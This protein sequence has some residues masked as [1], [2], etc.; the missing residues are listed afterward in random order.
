MESDL[1]QGLLTED[2]FFDFF[3]QGR[4]TPAVSR[5]SRSAQRQ[6]QLEN[7]DADESITKHNLP[8]PE[9]LAE[10]ALRSTCPLSAPD[11]WRGQR[12]E[13]ILLFGAVMLAVF[14]YGVLLLV[15]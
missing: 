12:H 4:P 3:A 1:C 11:T 2:P 7:L 5:E 8:L 6:R 9:P 14:W 10:T 15:E 13:M